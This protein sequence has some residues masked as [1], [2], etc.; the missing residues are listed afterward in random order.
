PRSRR[1]RSRRARGRGARGGRAVAPGAHARSRGR[2]IGAR[3]AVEGLP[4]AGPILTIGGARRCAELILAAAERTGRRGALS[5]PVAGGAAAGGAP[6][7]SAGAAAPGLD[8][9]HRLHAVAARGALKTGAVA[10]E[11]RAALGAAAVADLIMT[12]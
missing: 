12:P 6:G 3:G 9:R 1:A 5:H 4:I 10:G 7:G 2:A 11:E 8:Q